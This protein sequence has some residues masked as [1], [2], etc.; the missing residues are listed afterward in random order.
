MDSP[1]MFLYILCILSS[2][3]TYEPYFDACIQKPRAGET[4]EN[5]LI[6]EREGYPTL[7]CFHNQEITN[8][9]LRINSLFVS[10]ASMSGPPLLG[11]N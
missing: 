11:S 2:H 5:T 7:L 1:E 3:V 8:D 4:P 10:Y 9:S 6:G